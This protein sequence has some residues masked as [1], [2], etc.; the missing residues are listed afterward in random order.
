MVDRL[1]VRRA[2]ASVSPSLTKILTYITGLC[3]IPKGD[4]LY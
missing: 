1:T 2:L 3:F 4:L